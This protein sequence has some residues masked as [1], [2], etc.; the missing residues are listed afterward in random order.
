[1]QPRARSHCLLAHGA[2]RTLCARDAACRDGGSARARGL[3]EGARGGKPAQRPRKPVRV[4]EQ[5]LPLSWSYRKGLLHSAPTE[6]EQSLGIDSASVKTA[7]HSHPW[8]HSL[9]WRAQETYSRRAPPPC[10][11]LSP[12]AADPRLTRACTFE[13]IFTRAVRRGSAYGAIGPSSHTASIIQ[14]LRTVIAPGLPG[15]YELDDL[16]ATLLTH[17]V[18]VVVV[19]AFSRILHWG[20]SRVQAPAPSSGRGPQ[21]N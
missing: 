10:R 9:C 2:R 12:R 19:V 17:E 15:G 1:M 7:A 16:C 21:D 20:R 11:P 8:S 3:T 18:A 14:L 4:F 6:R 5:Q 13:V